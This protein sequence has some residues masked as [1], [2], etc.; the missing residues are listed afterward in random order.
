MLVISGYFFEPT[1]MKRELSLALVRMFCVSQKSL[2][3]QQGLYFEMVPENLLTRHMVGAIFTYIFH[4]K[5]GATG[6]I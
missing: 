6:D 2:K 4:R 3:K 5:S 1:L